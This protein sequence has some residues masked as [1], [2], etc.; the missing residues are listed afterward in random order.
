MLWI[1]IEDV[2]NNEPRYDAMPYDK[3][4]MQILST[5]LNVRGLWKVCE[6]TKA[7]AIASVVERLDRSTDATEQEP[8][9]EDNVV[10]IDL[11]DKKQEVTRQIVLAAMKKAGWRPTYAARLAGM[12]RSTIYRNL[13]PGE[14]EAHQRQFLE[15]D[16]M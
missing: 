16:G 2:S 15:I 10:N 6:D 3:E 7:D 5:R 4:S 12:S 1:V 8:A 13:K 14:I 11:L 9:H